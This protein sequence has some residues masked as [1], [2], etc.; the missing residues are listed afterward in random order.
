MY[1]CF[2][3]QTWIGGSLSQCLFYEGC[4]NLSRDVREVGITFLSP[5]LHFR[6]LDLDQCALGYYFNSL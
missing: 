2:L 6:L 1:L 3:S 4:E 5:H